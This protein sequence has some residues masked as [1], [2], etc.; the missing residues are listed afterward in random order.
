[1]TQADP[2]LWANVCRQC[3]QGQND[4]H[5]EHGIHAPMLHVGAPGIP[6]Q[7]MTPEH[8]HSYHLDCLPV[9]L[10]A[11]HRPQHGVAIDAAKAGKRGQEL[12]AII[13]KAAAD[14]RATEQAWLADEAAAYEATGVAN[15]D[16]THP[17]HAMHAKAGA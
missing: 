10:D 4:D 8:I 16:P 7:A 15:T 9:E 5:A 11:Q 17:M 1:M 12:H 2:R 14:H 13:Q 6:F 3:G